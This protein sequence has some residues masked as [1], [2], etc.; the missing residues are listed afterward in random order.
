MT[1]TIPSPSAPLEERVARLE[2]NVASLLSRVPESKNDSKVG[3]PA[4]V[5]VFKDNPIHDEIVRLGQEYR[6]SQHPTSEENTGD[7]ES[8][9]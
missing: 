5:G 7:S 2:E 1:T 4:I 8:A 6:E 3:W 9:A